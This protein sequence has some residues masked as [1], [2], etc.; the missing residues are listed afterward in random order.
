M[1]L[2]TGEAIELFADT[3]EQQQ[4]WIKYLHLMSMFPY[5]PIPEEP[6]V[7]PIRDSYRSK[8][9]HSNYDAG[10]ELVPF[11]VLPTLL[12]YSLFC[13]QCCVNFALELH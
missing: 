7:N 8:I 11:K 1:L 2:Q 12:T 9:K 5:S 13:M 4:L 10:E 3:R 6:R